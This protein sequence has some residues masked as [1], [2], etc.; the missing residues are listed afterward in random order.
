MRPICAIRAAIRASL[1]LVGHARITNAEVR[2]YGSER[3]GTDFAKSWNVSW[4]EQRKSQVRG[5][6]ASCGEWAAY[7]LNEWPI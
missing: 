7:F 1:A 3:L 5:L 2:G 4:L 6:N